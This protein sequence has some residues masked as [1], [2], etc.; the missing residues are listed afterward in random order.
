MD[1]K[2]VLLLVASFGALFLWQW[3]VGVWFPPVPKP[4]GATNITASVTNGLGTNVALPATNVT[5][6]PAAAVTSAT[7]QIIT[8]ATNIPE[9]LEVL[10][11]GDVIYTFTSR[12][13]GLKQIQLKRFLETVGCD[14]S[15]GT[16]Q[17]ATLNDHARI[18]VL[19]MQADDL[20]GD[21]DFKLTR[22]SPNSLIAE[23]V[24]ASGL[25]IVNQFD[26][27]SNYQV[28]ARQRI[29]NTS[30]LNVTL[31]A[32]RLSV[33]TATP[34]GPRDTMAEMGAFWFNGEKAEHVK[35]PSF[36][37][38]G[39]CMGMGRRA[40]NL[41]YKSGTNSIRWAAVHNQ[42]FTIA[43]VPATN[44]IGT[45][46]A[47][48]RIDLPAPTAQEIAAD[49]KIVREPRGLEAMVDYPGVT[50]A[51][52]QTVE[53]QFT[54]YAGPKRAKLLARVG[55]ETD[56][57]MDFGFFSPIS[58]IMLRV[59]NGIHSLIAPI[60]PEKLGKY[61]MSLVTMTILIKLV[62]WPLT[63]KSTRSMKRMQALSPE[64]KKLQEKYKDDPM[65]MNKK[66]MEFWKEHKVSPMSGCWPMMIQLPIFFALFRMIPNAIEL[67]G[68][69]FLWAC[70][71]SKPDTIFMIPGL[72]PV[73]P[74]PLIMGVTMLVQ[75]RMQPPSPGMDPAQQTMMKYM[76][77]MFLVFLYNQPAGLTLYWTVQ[78]L[79]TIVQTK[80]TKAKEEPA[81]VVPAPKV[82]P[83]KKK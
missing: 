42:F 27:G 50:L 71:L 53:R 17:F 68:T 36:E 51:P 8:L 81:A 45:Q 38:G 19:A 24:L 33:G 31:P 80:L 67:R 34:M 12:G 18:P 26:L 76:P 23:K 7:N 48:H 1:R 58:K 72:I 21:N 77:L 59:M 64:L 29:E 60:V 13:G 78:N 46:F 37:G 57:I 22:S 9:K 79:L 39:G 2:T 47:V 49:S 56:K 3:L 52:N 73:N 28:A 63:Q 41:D 32:Q 61:A 83:K 82:A 65:K 25:R 43:V 10:E 70:D 4:P 20:L 35:Q 16:N 11:T 5:P 54:I 15:S 40:A 6:A 74:L 66:V 44:S 14:R 75:A 30:A 62:F 69:P 55:R